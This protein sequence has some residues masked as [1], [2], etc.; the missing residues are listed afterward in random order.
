MSSCRLAST[1]GSNRAVVSAHT[2]YVDLPLLWRRTIRLVA[3]RLHRNAAASG[4]HQYRRPPAIQLRKSR[5]C[6]IKAHRQKTITAHSGKVNAQGNARLRRTSCSAPATRQTYS[7]I[8]ENM[9]R[10]CVLGDLTKLTRLCTE[11]SWT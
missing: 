1:D 6:L 3:A 9:N 8:S 2:P 11:S 10:E 4:R 7:D 5:I